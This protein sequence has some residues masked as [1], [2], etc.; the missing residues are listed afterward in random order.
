M[1]SVRLPFLSIYLVVYLVF[2]YAPILVIP[3]FSFNTAAA[4]TLPL[5]GFTLKWHEMVWGNAQMLRAALNS[6]IVGLSVSLLTTTLGVL[7]ARA[8]SR[9]RFPGHKAASGLIMAPLFL[10]EIIVAVSLLTIILSL[11]FS[12]SLIA[13]I[14]GHTVFCLPYAMSVLTAGFQNLDPSLEE[15]SRDLGETAFGTF[16][17]VILPV[18]SPAIL[19][20]LLVSFT[21]SFDEFILAFFLSGSEP[22][23]PVYIWGQLRFAARLPAVL[24]LG[25]IILVL[26]I[27]LLAIAEILRK[28]AEDRLT[29]MGAP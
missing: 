17:R 11:G 15:A 1:K 2:L 10:P 13:V 24:A 9:H 26:S 21:I 7:A 18:V 28:R 8:L 29:A 22:T 12:A 4:P 20:S 27:A 25:S 6:L 5:S 3:V 14:L 23:L 19:S 16:R